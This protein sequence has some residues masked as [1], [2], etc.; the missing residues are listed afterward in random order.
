M[1]RNS[2]HKE[3]HE[4]QAREELIDYNDITNIQFTS[5]TTGHPKGATLTHHNILNNSLFVGEGLGYTDQD[6]ICIPGPLYHCLGM[7]LGNLC[8][9]NFGATIVMPGS[10]YEA[11]SLL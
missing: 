11:N 4:M 3:A 7:V 8:S 10:S 6:R 1:L 2:T 9:L 5:G